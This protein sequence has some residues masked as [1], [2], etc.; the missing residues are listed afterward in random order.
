MFRYCHTFVSQRYDIFFGRATFSRYGPRSCSPWTK[1]ESSVICGIVWQEML[2]TVRLNHFSIS[3]SNDEQVCST[4][5]PRHQS[6]A[7]LC[8]SFDARL[9][10]YKQNRTRNDP[11][12]GRHLQCITLR[13]PW[14]LSRSCVVTT[15]SPLYKWLFKGDTL[16]IIVTVSPNISNDIG[17]CITFSI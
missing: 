17:I 4:V 10:W 2:D 12:R 15:L 5:I 3:S 6:T 16:Y 13:Q 11:V 7:W 8:Q 14:L 1:S 9:P